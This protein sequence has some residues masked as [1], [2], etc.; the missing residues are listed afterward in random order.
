MNKKA[1]TKNKIK[2]KQNKNIHTHTYI[3]YTHITDARMIVVLVL[4]IKKIKSHHIIEFV[5]QK[6]KYQSKAK[7][8]KAKQTNRLKV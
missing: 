7:Q 3:K 5:K 2:T 1:K 6:Q 8:S 4:L